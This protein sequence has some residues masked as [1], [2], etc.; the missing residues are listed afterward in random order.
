MFAP[1][2]ALA[3]S[4]PGWIQN[5]WIWWV[6]AVIVVGGLLIF[7]L[8]E[9][10]RLA[11]RRV[12][13]ISSVCFA[14]SIRRKVLWVIP[15]AIL[16]VIAISLLQHAT[17]PQEAIRQTIKFCLFAS[18][19]MV[20]VT[21]VILACTNLPR[22][23]ENRVI[24]TIVT[25]PT[26]RLEIV[27][28]K[29]LGFIRVSGLIVLIM[30]AFTFAYL[31]LENSR[32]G[33]Q[34]AERLKTEKDPS[35]RT[36]LE[37]YQTAG[38]LGTRSLETPV[39]F[40]IWEHD[41]TPE[42]THWLTGGYG[43][44]ALVPFD[45]SDQDKAALEAAG[46]DP[47]HKSVM[48]INTMRLKRSK[49]T[50]DEEQW[51][52]GKKLALE[53]QGIGPTVGGA[54]ISPIP[55]PQ[56]TLRVLD[57]NMSVVLAEKD[58]HGGNMATARAGIP[59]SSTEPYT[60]TAGLSAEAI[61]TLIQTGKFYIQ[62]IPETYSV[63]YEIAPTPTVLDIFDPGTR[64]EQVIK[65][66]KPPGELKFISASG[67][68][69]MKIV[70]KADGTGSI[71]FFRFTGAE[72]PVDPSKPAVFRLHAGVE[73][74]GEYDASKAWSVVTLTV[75]NRNTGQTSPPV[76]CHPETSQ[77][78]PVAVPAEYVKGGNFD[79]FVRGMD[80]GQFVGLTSSSVELISGE[81]S[82]VVNLLASLFLLWLLSILVV[83]IA[84]FTST[85]LSWPIAI[86]LTLLILLGHWGVEQ[87]G[88]TLNPG[89]GRGV[90]AEF[91]VS[92]KT[93]NQLISSSV[94]ALAKML[95]TVSAVLPDLSKFP[96]M[97]NI[98]RGV[99]TPP[100]Q[101]AEAFGVLFCYGLPLLV[102]SFIILKNKEVA[103]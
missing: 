85:F 59:L 25:K 83:T 57:P 29:V 33:A 54:T 2:T 103:P 100:R 95:T 48:I 75:R 30:G 88:D 27:L 64:S 101:V 15:L 66:A 9:M 5:Y 77:D 97:D 22:E 26:T 73:R 61:R 46:A 78:I 7:G 60:I 67:R 70:G 34:V 17:D 84:I 8:D 56:L 79:V 4:I 19:L 16:G 3:A 28:G 68:Y 20:T 23:I 99:A 86:V 96:V 58:I 18:G 10:R 14:E 91:G 53:N 45:L 31:G 69:G 92:D 6:A 87:L 40:Q 72:T 90:A 52:V 35:T 62:V 81:H 11:I 41:V 43:Y 1:A 98:T 21:A 76:E 94:D 36:T 51:I 32:L 55:I 93:Q 50:S 80:N 42:G 49:P 89:V 12:W 82:F 13:A 71:G 38:L 39:D 37:A 102:I 44:T 24:F 65:Q 63:E 47:E 74:T